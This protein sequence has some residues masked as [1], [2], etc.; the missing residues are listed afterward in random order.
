MTNNMDEFEHEDLGPMEPH[1]GGGGLKKGLVEAWRTQP[2]FK[3]MVI[4]IVVGVAIAGALGVFSGPS[5]NEASTMMRTPDV[6]EPPGPKDSPYFIEQN[7]MANAERAEE[8]IQKGTSALPTPV[9]QNIDLGDL[10]NKNKED[11]LAEFRAE[12]ER[13][14]Q[15]INQERQQNAQQM[16]QMQQQVQRPPQQ[17]QQEDDSLAKAMQKQMEQLMESWVPHK[18][19]VVEGE[20]LKEKGK[21]RVQETTTAASASVQPASTPSAAQV[22]AGKIIVQA[23]TVNYAQLLTEANSDVQGPILAQVLSGPMAGGRAIGQFQVMNDFLVLRF[24]LINFKGKD[25]P[26]SILALDPNTTLGGMATDVD[27][28]YFDRVILPAAAAFAQQFGQALGQGKS[29]VAVT[30]NA[31]VVDQASKSYKEA[32]FAG[33]GQAGQ[34]LSQF[35]QQQADQIKPLVRVAVGTPLGLFFLSS[36]HENQEQLMT[37]GTSP[38]AYSGQAGAGAYQG[39]PGAGGYSAVQGYASPTTG[40]PYPTGYSTNPYATGVNPYAA[41]TPGYMGY[42]PAGTGRYTPNTLQT[43]PSAVNII[44]PGQSGGGASY[45]TQ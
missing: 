30:N 5:S 23:G 2:L 18:M 33:F 19:A 26:V 37:A 21:E 27:H 12:T 6:R 20:G 32:V 36:V 4:M 45:Y 15:E 16:Q 39:V 25:Y 43:S 1:G 35:L 38:Y 13:L 41:S 14:K 29:S 7:K 11:P 31:V 17:Q 24:N 40:T 10:T 28:R 44:M 42:N 8:A 34:S 3:L 22:T 9:G